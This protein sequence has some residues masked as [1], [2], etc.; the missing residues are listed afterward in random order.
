[1]ANLRVT[2]SYPC[3][4]LFTSVIGAQH[5]D[6][7]HCVC[8]CELPCSVKRPRL[9]NPLWFNSVFLKT[10]DR[11]C[12]C[13]SLSMLQKKKSGVTRS[14][15][16][17]NPCRGQKQ[18]CA[19]WKMNW[20]MTLYIRIGALKMQSL[21][22]AYP[23]SLPLIEQTT[24]IQLLLRLYPKGSLFNLLWLQCLPDHR[25]VKRH[26]QNCN[27]CSSTF[28]LSAVWPY[29][30]ESCLLL[31]TQKSPRAACKHS[32]MTLWKNIVVSLMLRMNAI[33]KL[34]WSVNLKSK[35]KRK[36]SIWNICSSYDVEYSD[37][38]H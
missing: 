17:R 16:F 3:W 32:T 22:Y 27:T 23:P 25:S 28:L 31:D 35:V 29:S 19:D 9:G 10:C 1:M 8:D 26:A 18:K 36:K 5:F 12:L 38:K 7:G 37:R 2:H 20:K 21:R 4:L 15:L 6:P 11:P 14:W 24:E 30:P 34:A 13:S 33:V